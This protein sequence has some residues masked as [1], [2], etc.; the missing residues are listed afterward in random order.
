MFIV[1]KGS[2]GKCKERRKEKVSEWNGKG[3]R[4]KE[5]IQRKLGFEF[6][7]KEYRGYQ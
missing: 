3:R 6:F 5:G 2:G 4:M 1:G 7:V